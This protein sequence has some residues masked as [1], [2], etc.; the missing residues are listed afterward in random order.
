[1]RL[2]QVHDYMKHLKFF[3]VFLI[4]GIQM[5]ILGDP[6]STKSLLIYCDHGLCNFKTTE[7]IE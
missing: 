7:P 5:E 6:D 2:D 3:T 1:M 4:K